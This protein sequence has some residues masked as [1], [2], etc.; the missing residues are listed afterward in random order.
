MY[1]AIP[2][3]KKIKI[4]VDVLIGGYEFTIR[5]RHSRRIYDGNC[6]M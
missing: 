2:V 1:M 3:N 4:T 6:F 5:V